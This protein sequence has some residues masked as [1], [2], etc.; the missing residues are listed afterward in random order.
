MRCPA[1]SETSTRR[2]PR[3]VER[4]DV[5]SVKWFPW[6]LKYLGSAAI[7]RSLRRPTL[8]KRRNQR[9]A[10]VWRIA[11]AQRPSILH[12]AGTIDIDLPR[13]RQRTR[14]HNGALT[15]RKE[16]RLRRHSSPT[17]TVATRRGSEQIGANQYQHSDRSVPELPAD[18][19]STRRLAFAPHHLN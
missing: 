6:R 3:S 14:H 1:A 2:A 18:A 9:R 19:A 11:P 8:P 4:V 17:Q 15:K 12:H 13:P 16:H 5:E 7:F 10:R